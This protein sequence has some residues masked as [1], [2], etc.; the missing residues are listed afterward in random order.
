MPWSHGHGHGHGAVA[1]PFGPASFFNPR[2]V[3]GVVE[4]YRQ[5]AQELE[6]GATV[7]YSMCR[8][9]DFP[10]F[11]LLYRELAAVPDKAIKLIVGGSLL[12]F[13]DIDD[14]LSRFDV[15]PES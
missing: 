9:G 6:P 8:I 11:Y 12:R 13:L 2:T 10:N 15:D 5:L 1:R 4:Y 7:C 14:F 3:W